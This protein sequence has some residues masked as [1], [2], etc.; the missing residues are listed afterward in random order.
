MRGSATPENPPPNVVVI[1]SRALFDQVLAICPQDLRSHVAHVESYEEEEAAAKAARGLILLELAP[2]RDER[3]KDILSASDGRPALLYLVT[4]CYRL[5]DAEKYLL[6]RPQVIGYCPREALGYP[7]VQEEIRRLV[8]EAVTRTGVSTNPRKSVGWVLPEASDD[9]YGKRRLVSLFIGG[10]RE[11][12]VSLRFIINDLREKTVSRDKKTAVWK[13]KAWVEEKLDLVRQLDGWH[14]WQTKG[15]DS[16]KWVQDAEREKRFRLFADGRH[17]SIT[18]SIVLV[19]GESGTGKSLIARLIHRGVFRDQAV[20]LGPE[21]FLRQRPFQDILSLG[22]PE[23]LVE[24]E[25]FGAL[26]EAY[27]DRKTTTPGKILMAYGGVLFLDEIGD[28]SLSLQGKLLKF[29]DTSAVTPLGW[30]SGAIPVP[31]I[32]VA[33]TNAHLEKKVDKGEFRG[34]LLYRLQRY[35]VTIPPLR[36]RLWDL[37]RMVDFVLQNPEVNKSPDGRRYA[38]YIADAALDRLRGHPFPGNF[39]EL[40][41]CL[42]AAIH[43]ARLQGSDTI[44][45]EHLEL[46]NPE[47]ARPCS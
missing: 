39:R 9:D 47:E 36:E 41:S 43:R 30:V 8:Q 42:Q 27:T 25:L 20:V 22:L 7:E 37:D 24:S 1:G 33:A 21:E 34:D 45:P 23:T 38:D 5:E 28:M 29:L 12:I 17:P 11:F 46:R 31:V 2:D 16:D 40:E 26:Q 14:A 3:G 18:S 15:Q 4:P 19:R 10:M 13:T 44:L 35:S 6:E 32:I